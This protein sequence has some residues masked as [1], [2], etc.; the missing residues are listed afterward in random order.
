MSGTAEVLKS[1]GWIDGGDS[2]TLPSSVSAESATAAAEV[3]Q[4]KIAVL[5]VLY[6]TSLISIVS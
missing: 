4:A 3:I 6:I 1:L 2:W 5:K